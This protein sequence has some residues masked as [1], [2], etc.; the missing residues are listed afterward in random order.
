LPHGRER[1]ARSVAGPGTRRSRNALRGARG[2]AGQRREARRRGAGLHRLPA[3]G[4]DPDAPRADVR[5]DAGEP[6]GD[7]WPGATPL[8]DPPDPRVPREDH[9]APREYP[10]ASHEEGL[11]TT[12]ARLGG[13]VLDWLSIDGKKL[14]VT[15]V[16]RTFAYGYLATSLGLYL[17]RLGM[18]PTELGPVFTA[19]RARSA[20]M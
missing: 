4:R 1:R 20:P 8:G 14:L 11:R 16:L 18:G 15:R 10:R 19:A 3:L 7:H 5:R 17:D 13:G 6:T 12:G 9:R 2:R